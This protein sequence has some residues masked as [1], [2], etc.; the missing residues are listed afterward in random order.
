MSLSQIINVTKRS[1][2][3]F[4][5]RRHAFGFEKEDPEPPGMTSG[6]ESIEL[7]ESTVFMVQTC[8]TNN[9]SWLRS[10]DA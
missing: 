5:I 10:Q 4:S 2:P 7:P 3:K 8:L 1:G 6:L 9:K